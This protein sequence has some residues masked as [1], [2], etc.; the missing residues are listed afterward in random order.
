MAEMS[1]LERWL[2]NSPFRAWFQS[3]EIAAFIRWSGASAE[4][5]VLDMGCGPGVSTALILKALRPRRLAAFDV[6]P[7]MIEAARRRLVRHPRSGVL[8]LRVA[9]ATQMPYEDA[10]FHAVFESGIIH[11]VPNWRAALGE[12]SR[13]VKPGGA[14]CFAEPSRGRLQ[15]SLYRLLPH[16][17]ESMFG[18]EELRAALEDAGLHLGGPVRRLPLWDICGVAQREG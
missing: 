10:R 16:A 14:F 9:D 13:V 8:N 4:A 6:D 5:S 2:V 15:R 18:A 12:V 3:G 17:V 1:V 11:H 7:S